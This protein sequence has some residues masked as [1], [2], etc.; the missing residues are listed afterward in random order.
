MYT[1]SS[2]GSVLGVV[3]GGQLGRMM[4]EAAAPLGVE[5]IVLDPTPDCPAA[6][7]AR[8]Q[9]VGGFDD[10]EAIAEL[11]ERVDALTFEIELA[12]PDVLESV[13]E[14]NDVPV[15]PSPTTLRTIQDKLVQKRT[16]ADAGIA[17]PEFRAVSGVSELRDALSELG[18]KAMV[19]ARR[20]G[21]DGRGNAPIED[22]AEAEATLEE[23]GG[24]AMVEELVEFE[25]ELSVIGV[26]GKEEIATYVVGENVHEEEILRETVVPARTDDVV[27]ER[28]QAVARDVLDLM[29]G[30]GTY[31]IEL[32]EKDGEILVNEIA[33]RPHNSGHWTI[34]GADSSQFEQHVRAVLGLPLGSTTLRDPVVSKNVLGDDRRAREARLS[35]VE[36]LLS[37]PTAHL[38]WYGKRE[39]RPLRKMGH[40]TVFGEDGDSRDE[41][42]ESARTYRRYVEFEA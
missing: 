21:Y 38:H 17:V 15:Q 33:P 28:A 10:R 19:K 42:L 13:G 24:E 23:I 6:P 25:R 26:K 31:G 9:I 7:L 27:R 2:P 14:R 3:G 40:F 32:F 36:Q 11:A 12:D 35:G 39:V 37:E 4:A 20:G 18:G 1:L 8:D 22:P 34:E 30:R 5:L 41:L 16:L 29:N